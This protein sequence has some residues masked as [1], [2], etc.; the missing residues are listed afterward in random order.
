[1]SDTITPAEIAEWFSQM[2]DEREWTPATINRYS[3]AMSKAFKL[4]IADGKVH[5]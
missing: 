5:E 2:E 1:M 4:G 3:A